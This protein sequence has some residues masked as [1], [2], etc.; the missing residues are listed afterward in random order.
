MQRISKNILDEMVETK[1]KN[2]SDE[3]KKIAITQLEDFIDV[4]SSI[5][6]NN[7]SKDGGFDRN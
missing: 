7:L 6:I 1:M 4:V 2:C 5:I 3:E